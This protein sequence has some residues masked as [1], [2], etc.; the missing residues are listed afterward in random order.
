MQPRPGIGDLIWHLP[1]IHALAGDGRVDLMTKRSTAADVLLANDAAVRR[2]VW[3][4]R[5]PPER[6]GRHDG[7]LGFARLVGELRAVGAGA[8]VLLHQSASLAAALAAAGI[9]RRFGYG[10]GSQRMFL[11]AG[12]ALAAGDAPRHPTAQAQ[13]Y[14]TA[15]GLGTLADDA[16][17]SVP[18]E[19]A[20]AVHEREGPL[21]R[22]AVLGVG[23]TE[24]NRCW[25]TARFAALAQLLLERGAAGV[26]LLAAASEARLAH[27]VVTLLGGEPGVRLAVGWP[28]GEVMALL[29]QAGLFIG[30]DS[31]MLNVRVAL[32]GVGYGLFGVS[33]PLTHSARFVPIVSAAGA[34]AGM[35]SIG[36][37]D[38]VR[39]LDR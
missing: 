37:E 39:A 13:A 20:A 4:D 17:L 8:S 12:P 3:L 15:L 6:R 26:M 38:V 9:P 32:G 35:E 25:P 10:Y 7:P 21:A 16:V 24:A 34:R 36:V 18:P 11:N 5:N 2:I 28:L 27:E 33:G 14:A 1:L 29:R 31:G 23:S 22:W 30:N 19:A